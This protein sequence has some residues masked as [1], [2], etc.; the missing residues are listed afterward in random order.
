MTVKIQSFPTFLLLILWVT[1]IQVMM[2][3]QAENWT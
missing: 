1:W 3:I 2:G